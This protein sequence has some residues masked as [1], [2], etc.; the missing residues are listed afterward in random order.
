MITNKIQPVI[1]AGGSGTRLWPLSRKM[2]PKQFLALDNSANSLLQNTVKRIDSLDKLPPIV[3]CN[4]EHRFIVAE[5]LR[6]IDCDNAKIILEPVGKNTAPAIALASLIANQLY[7]ENDIT[8]L[9][10]S[11]DHVIK[12]QLVFEQSIN[13]ARALA[14]DDKLVTFGIVPT[15][16]ETGYGYIQKGK[17]LTNGFEVA[18]FVEKPDIATAEE[19]VASHDYLWNSGMF[20]FK[21]S[22]YLE[23]LKTYASNIYEYCAKSVATVEHDMDFIRVISKVFK[24]A[25]VI[26][27]IMLSWKKLIM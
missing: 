27:L 22:G 12:N 11:A 3:I 16:A 19:Y 1:L 25:Q 15:K 7:A 9:I 8:L 5:Q 4:E 14:I 24:S 18:R 2:Y 23:A 17:S 13:K 6:Q 10:L 21:P 20:M 26:R